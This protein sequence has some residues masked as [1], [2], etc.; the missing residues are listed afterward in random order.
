[1]TGNTIMNNH[2]IITENLEP[3]IDQV[4]ADIRALFGAQDKEKPSRLLA[5]VKLITSIAQKAKEQNLDPSNDEFLEETIQKLEDIRKLITKNNNPGFK[6]SEL[7]YNERILN[8]FHD[9]LHSL[10]NI[11]TTISEK[12]RPPIRRLFNKPVEQSFYNL[13]LNLAKVRPLKLRGSVA[14][15]DTLIPYIDANK[16]LESA[17]RLISIIQTEYPNEEALLAT[18]TLLSEQIGQFHIDPT[19]IVCLTE[20]IFAGFKTIFNA[21]KS[22]YKSM[23]DVKEADLDGLKLPPPITE[24]DNPQGS[25][26]QAA[27]VVEATPNLKETPLSLPQGLTRLART[28]SYDSLPVFDEE[29][30]HDGDDETVKSATCAAAAED[31]SRF[32]GSNRH[33]LLAAPAPAKPSGSGVNLGLLEEM[34]AAAEMPV[35]EDSSTAVSPS[36][37][38]FRI[39]FLK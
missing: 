9:Y 5:L 39:Q 30:E 31:I 2:D 26:A 35:A 8:K 22:K 25:L 20:N 16:L 29:D 37:G 21:L 7:H 33:G 34:A 11:L 15:R 36:D 10:T 1:M 12:Y 32:H 3:L 14:P 27:A 28:T 23:V 24:P 18:S 17:Q 4:F 19:G 38:G 6:E 13:E